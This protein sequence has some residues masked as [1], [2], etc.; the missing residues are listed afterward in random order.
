MTTHHEAVSIF[1]DQLASR[2]FS[3]VEQIAIMRHFAKRF[4]AD[5][6]DAA[7]RQHATWFVAIRPTSCR[8]NHLLHER[9]GIRCRC[10]EHEGQGHTR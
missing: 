7:V 3:P 1:L 2:A 4:P 5:G 9:L 8:Q 10:D 6:W